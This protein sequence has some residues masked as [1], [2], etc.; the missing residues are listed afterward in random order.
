MPTREQLASAL[1][2]ADKAGDIAAARALAKAIQ[3]L[4]APRNQEGS[5]ADPIAQGATFGFADEIAGALG[6][7]V[8]TLDP[9]LSGT[10][11][12]ERY[13]GIR[14][15]ARQGY[16]DFKER[17]PGTAFAAEIAGGVGTGAL[18]AGRAAAAGVARS[19]PKLA[20]T[21][22]AVGGVAGTGFSEADSVG[23]VVG[24]AATG[25]AIG[26]VA[27]GLLP[28]VATA[29][30]KGATAPLRYA[31]A[32]R[33][34]RPVKAL[35]Q[36]ISRDGLT[37]EKVRATLDKMPA[38]AAAIVDAG[39]ENLQSLGRD[40]TIQPGKAK[41]I[42]RKLF[43]G[44]RALAPQRIDTAVR[45]ALNQTE[46]FYPAKQAL[47]EQMKTVAAPF[48]EQ[49]Y[50]SPVMLN[51]KLKAILNRP[52]MA[53]AL[54]EGRKMAQNEGGVIGGNIQLLD[55]AKRALDDK[56]DVAMRSGEKQ[57]ARALI[58]TKN[59]LLDELDAQVP[60]Y[61]QA[62]DAFAGQKGLDDALEAGRKFMSDDVELIQE[63]LGGMTQSEKQF[64]RMGAIRQIR[65]LVLSKSDTADAY[66]AIFNSPLKRERV[67]ALF[68]NA[69]E[70]AKFQRAMLSEARMFESGTKAMGNSAKANKL[71]GMADLEM[72]PG[73]LVDAATGSPSIAAINALKTWLRRNAP[74][75]KNENMRNQLAEMLFS[76][77]PAIQQRALSLI[78]EPVQV[79]LMRE[80][81]ALQIQS[82]V[83]GSEAAVSRL[84]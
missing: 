22:A 74:A 1:I 52:A 65:D 29:I 66:K 67:Q 84:N 72:D 28:P 6:A 68:P 33:A 50:K 80:I 36:A 41:N 21:G 61:K 54:Q 75:I 17:N 31:Q 48:Y 30:G 64:F 53:S 13:R 35:G 63:L 12:G 2:N 37:P 16:S 47:A 60:S 24:D 27:G 49:A 8:G 7:A 18:G 23:G 77:D 38:G 4:D 19:L 43:T 59:E 78:A 3:E 44:R 51:P 82:A 34:A 32:T 71:A 58:K 42:A 83:V 26:G 15:A 69:R 73:V 11:F 20:G 39:G 5:I 79:K 81:P 55:Y 40:V 25:T 46:E 70:F 45:T 57:L 76:T 56:I 10:T 9:R 14:D 62:R